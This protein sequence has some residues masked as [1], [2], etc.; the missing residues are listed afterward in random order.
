[1]IANNGMCAENLDHA[2]LAV[3]FGTEAGK[4]YMLVKNS[5]SNTWGDHGFVKLEHNSWSC[6]CGCVDQPSIVKVAAKK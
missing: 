5:W 4:D 2:V 3:G 1:V 6:A